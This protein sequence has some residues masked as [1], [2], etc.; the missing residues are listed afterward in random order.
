[1]CQRCVDAVKKYF[2]DCPV[3]EYGNFLLEATPFPCG[4]AQD[5]E[6][7]LRRHKQARCKTWTDAMARAWRRCENAK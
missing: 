6:T 7:A 2:P 3:K 4:T 5:T 1:M